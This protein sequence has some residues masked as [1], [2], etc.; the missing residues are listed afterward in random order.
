MQNPVYRIEIEGDFPDNLGRGRLL[1][2]VY[3]GTLDDFP[4]ELLDGLIR[5]GPDAY[6]H[7]ALAVE[8]S[9]VRGGMVDY[10][11]SAEHA[12]QLLGAL[13]TLGQV[14]RATP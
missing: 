4:P 5:V 13:E 9:D 1:G 2:T 10:A 14:L 6:E 11:L 7:T 3:R 12:R 8:L